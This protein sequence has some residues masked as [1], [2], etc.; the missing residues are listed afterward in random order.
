MM[1]SADAGTAAIALASPRIKAANFVDFYM[2]VLSF[3]KFRAQVFLA[4]GKFA[5]ATGHPLGRLSL[6]RGMIWELFTD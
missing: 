5:A 2:I 3:C 6:R 4:R 1:L